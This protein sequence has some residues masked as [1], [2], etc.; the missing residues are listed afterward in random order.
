LISAP[1]GYGKSV[2]AASWMRKYA[3]KHA[4]LSLAETE[5][6]MQSFVHYLTLAIQTIVGQF[7]QDIVELCKIAEAPSP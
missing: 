1:S 5:N 6:N 4:W 7:G 3:V 2:F